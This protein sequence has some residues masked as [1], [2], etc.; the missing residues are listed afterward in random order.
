MA[1]SVLVCG[2]RQRMGRTLEEWHQYEAGVIVRIDLGTRT[3]SIVVRYVSPPSV[4]PPGPDPS[5]VFK[6]GAIH[7]NRLYACTQTEVMAFD[8]GSFDMPLYISRP[9]FNDVHH[10]LPL[11]GGQLAVASTG[12]DAVFLL[13]SSGKIVREWSTSGAPIWSRFDRQTDWRC[14]LTT[15]PHVSHPNYCFIHEEELWATR[16]EQRDAVCLNREQDRFDIGVERPHDGVLHCGKL[17]F[18]TVNGHITIF[19]AQSRTL[20]EDIDLNQ[21]SVG[22][23]GLGWCR[24]LLLLDDI[25]LVGFTRIRRTKIRETLS[26]MQRQ[27]SDPAHK[28]NTKPT[29]I[30]AYNLNKRTLLWELP[31]ENY[32][33]NAIFSL[34]AVS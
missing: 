34:H 19:D 18:T 9:E 4:I 17:Y 7:E 25:A 15:K 26:W 1:R 28:L 27:F 5:I 12:L 16:F 24:G 8:L 14:V 3:V 21:I 11:G 31:L 6:A 30:A 2:G 32:E 20:M 10:V 33:M 13:D 23:V 22:D 29:R